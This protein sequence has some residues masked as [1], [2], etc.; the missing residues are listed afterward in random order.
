[1]SEINCLI[2]DGNAGESERHNSTSGLTV[3]LMGSRLAPN[4]VKLLFCSMNFKKMFE[5][6][7]NIRI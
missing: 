6:Y 4:T 1:M 3:T 7:N 5:N 2:N